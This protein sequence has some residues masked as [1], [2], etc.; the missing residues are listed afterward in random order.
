MRIRVWEV[1]ADLGRWKKI[2]RSGRRRRDDSRYDKGSQVGDK[3]RQSA[4]GAFFGGR[5][6]LCVCTDEVMMLLR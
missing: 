5:L 4:A 3:A 1:R 2:H 6:L